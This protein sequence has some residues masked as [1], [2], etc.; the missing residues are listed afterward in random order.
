MEVWRI[1]PLNPLY[2]ASS[3]GRVRRRA[4]GKVLKPAKSGYYLQVCLSAR[5]ATR[6][7]RI[8]ELVASA[9]LGDRQPGEVIDHVNGDKLDN[10]AA[11]LQY[12]TQAENVRRYWQMVKDSARAKAKMDRQYT[13]TFK[14]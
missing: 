2:E 11:N 9:H 5:G 7:W 10:R 13:N 12:V 8:H 3:E 14:G 6:V 4:S 1:I